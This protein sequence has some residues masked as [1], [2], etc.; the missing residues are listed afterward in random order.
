MGEND[1]SRN[2]RGR[3][4]L[5]VSKKQGELEKREIRLPDGRRLIYY[6]FPGAP[7]Q[8]EPPPGPAIP[9]DPRRPEGG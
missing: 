1:G 2:G 8:P 9:V 6:S 3:K 4:V 7:R 5:A